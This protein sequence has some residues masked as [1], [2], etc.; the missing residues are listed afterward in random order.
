MDSTAG[1]PKTLVGAI[2]NGINAYRGA[3]WDRS[4]LEEIRRHVKDFIAQKFTVA[5]IQANRGT[6]GSEHDVMKLFEECTK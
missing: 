3:P 2:Q 6:F 5:R 1:T 4:E